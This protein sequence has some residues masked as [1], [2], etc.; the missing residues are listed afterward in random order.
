V[1]EKRR[2]RFEIHQQIQVA[3]RASLSPGDR[4]E[5]GDPM[6]FA[7]P[8]DAEDLRAAAA[9]PLQCQNII[10]HASSVSPP[11]WPEPP[12]ADPHNL[13]MAVVPSDVGR[14]ATFCRPASCKS[15]WPA[16]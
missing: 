8:R 12:P 16:A 9:E 7:L 4:A 11:T 6:S 1:I 10:A 15:V 5:Y 13:S 2:T 14:L 3:V